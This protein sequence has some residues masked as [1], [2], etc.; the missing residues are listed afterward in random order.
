[1]DAV[2]L[3]GEAIFSPYFSIQPT[4]TFINVVLQVPEALKVHLFVHTLNA[5]IPYVSLRTRVH[6]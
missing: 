3:P 2:P 1:M 6:P 4:P 5:D